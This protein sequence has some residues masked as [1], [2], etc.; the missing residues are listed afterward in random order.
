MESTRAII[1]AEATA[2]TLNHYKHGICSVFPTVGEEGRAI[3][4]CIEDHQFQPKNFWL[5]SATCLIVYIINYS[6]YWHH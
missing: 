6:L 4:V 1:E 5:V 3:V 2:Y